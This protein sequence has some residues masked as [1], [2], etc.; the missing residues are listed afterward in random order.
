VPSKVQHPSLSGL[1]SGVR[2][3]S[4]IWKKKWRAWLLLIALLGGYFAIKSLSSFSNNNDLNAEIERVRRLAGSGGAV[5]L[6]EALDRSVIRIPAGEFVMGSNVGRSDERPTRSVYLDAFEIDRFEVSNAQYRRFL[7]ATGRDEP[8]YWSGVEYPGGQADYPVVGVSWEDAAAYC[9]WAGKRL[10]TEAEW[11]KACR[12]SD[13]RLYPWGNTWDPMRGNV[14]KSGRSPWPLE[15]E[16]AWLL[17]RATPHSSNER[18]LQPIGSYP[19]GASPYGALDMVGNAS[20]WMWD[21]YNWSDYRDLPAQ[22]PRSPGPPWNHCLR[23]TPWFDPYG[24]T[25]WTQEL[26]RCAA[27]NS[28]HETRDPRVGF[29]CALSVT[30]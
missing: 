8:P 23:G 22:N 19:E 5:R 28:S 30:P 3:V 25:S 7:Q 26:S 20:E 27:R 12:G 6:A 18:R 9:T 11:E 16:Q 14:E 10:P 21:W 4:L 13:G 29:R 24:S 2:R 15:W 1:A 17:L